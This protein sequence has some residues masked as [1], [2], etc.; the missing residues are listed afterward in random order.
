MQS[1]ESLLPVSMDDSSNGI[2]HYAKLG[3]DV[4]G[5]T[6]FNLVPGERPQNLYTGIAKLVSKKVEKLAE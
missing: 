1:F 6:Q 2:Q 3:R 5:G 4:D